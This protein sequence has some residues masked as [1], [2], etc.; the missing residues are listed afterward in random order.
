MLSPSKHGVGFFNGL[1]M[2]AAIRTA[3]M[4]VLLLCAAPQVARAVAV[5]DCNEDGEVTVDELIRG[6]T[7]ALG[8]LSLADCLALD[9]DADNR[10]T[11]D[12]LIRAV[13]DALNDPVPGTLR[14]RGVIE[15]FYGPP[16]TFAQRLSMVRF[17]ADAGLNTY[18]YAPKL[19]PL[20]REHWPDPYP[21]EFLAHFGEL[22]TLGRSIGVRFVYALSP[23]LSLS[24]SQGDTAR[25]QAKLG[26]LLAAG[27]RDFCLLFDD[28]SAD[29]EGA[30]PEVQVA[31]VND[32]LAYLRAQ[33]PDTTLLFISNL[34]AGTADELATDTSPFRA[35]FPIGSSEY[36][37]AYERIDPAVPIMWTG[38]RV[39]SDRVTADAARAFRDF[40]G[41]SAVLW[42]NYPVNDVLFT[43]EFYLGPYVGR[44]PGIDRALTGVLLNPMLQAEASKIALWTAGRFFALGDAYDPQG[45]WE[46]ALDVVSG[47]RG[48]TAL[49]VLA[50]QFLSHP[51]IGEARESPR[52]SDA[53]DAF[54]AAPSVENRTALR[55][56]L[57]ECADNERALAD[58]LGNAA[59]LEEL[60]AP[61][62][63]LSLLGAA[64]LLALDLLELKENGTAVD[65]AAL[66]TQLAAANAIPWRVAA[67]TPLAGPIVLILGEREARPA[68]VFGKFFVPILEQ[69][70]E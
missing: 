28:I 38:A 8:E 57:A 36:Y 4:V 44:E 14:L 60:H 47:G 32:T 69:L 18:V 46:E 66:E 16:Y 42:D 26:T 22:A 1:P 11:I 61:S 48:T 37:R 15:G 25:V 17:L 34:Y 43:Q 13:N 40:A 39:F 56:L 68:D 63:K 21:A 2:V 10:A 9:G 20:H 54:L 23:G 6:V 35:L 19:D 24:P 49:R 59:L 3:W 7:I 55:A 31:L 67:N 50:E 27:V 5:G 29:G 58:T 33:A 62:R 70:R 45:A 41:R 30:D 52:L 12:E 65:T 51:L 53:V 64:G